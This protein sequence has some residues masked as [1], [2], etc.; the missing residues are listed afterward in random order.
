MVQILTLLLTTTDGVGIGSIR[1]KIIHS[2]RFVGCHECEL[3][4]VEIMM[5]FIFQGEPIV[6]DPLCIRLALRGM[7]GSGIAISRWSSLL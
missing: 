2:V 1:C 4:I 6:W 3:M 7:V 5:T